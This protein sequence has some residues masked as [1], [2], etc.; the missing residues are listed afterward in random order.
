M[1]LD[2]N[3]AR[4]VVRKVMRTRKIQI[5]KEQNNEHIK[6]SEKSRRSCGR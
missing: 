5:Q 2:I 6:L 4:L 1:T 3:E